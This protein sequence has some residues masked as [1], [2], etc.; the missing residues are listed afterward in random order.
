MRRW[1][2]ARLDAYLGA[3]LPADGRPPA[4]PPAGSERVDREAAERE[5][6]V[7]ALRTRTG[8]ALGA[9]LDAP[10]TSALGWGLEQQLLEPAAGDRVALSLRGRLLSNELF[11]RIV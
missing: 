7:L 10:F 4:L 8:L 6:A 9:S 3:L 1:N 5:T 2:A 11:A